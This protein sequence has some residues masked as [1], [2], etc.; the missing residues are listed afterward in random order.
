[1]WKTIFLF[2]SAKL[3]NQKFLQYIEQEKLILNGEKV[4]LAVSG[5]K[6]SMVMVHLFK[7]HQIPYG[8]A[9][10]NHSTR[11]GESD[12]DAKF[13]KDFADEN[14]V[15]YYEMVFDPSFSTTSN[16]QAKARS[17]RYEWLKT[18]AE[19]NGYAAIA[20][21]HHQN[22]NI[23]TFIMGLLR[24][25]GTRGL[26]G[27]APR[28]ELL[29]R[30]LLF[31]TRE[32]I[33][34]YQEKHGIEYKE[35]SSNTSHKYLRNKVRHTVLKVLKQVDELAVKKMNLSIRLIADSN[36]LLE[37]FIQQENTIVKWENQRCIIDLKALKSIPAASTFLWFKIN[38]YGF[39]KSDI[40]DML[41]SSRSGATFETPNY[42]ATIDRDKIFI[43]H[44]NQAKQQ[45]EDVCI[46]IPEAGSFKLDDH[47]HIKITI[48]DH[49]E[50]GKKDNEEYLGFDSN[51]LPLRLRKR[52]SGDTFKPLGMKGKNQK[53]KD[54]IV[55][56]KLTLEEKNKL[57]LLV[58]QS[59]EII[60]VIPHRISEA[61]KVTPESKFI[62]KLEY[63]KS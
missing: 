46:D 62:I 25:A 43:E 12:I 21:G 23:E 24:S 40:C 57:W 34:E 27:I 8:I 48:A 3:M 32:E 7:A 9:H 19:A 1:M 50:F 18:I 41:D 16:F 5:G 60:S 33:N 56:N 11:N 36:D 4:L 35:D 28:K 6:D 31:A 58:D 55:N 59:N 13:V 44:I 51:P 45:P 47:S 10:I 14:N 38:E 63:V 17:R 26:S 54:F 61:Y 15:E 20:T 49:L 53:I 30:P 42:R 52:V 22:D 29:I 2:R 39:T 37:Y